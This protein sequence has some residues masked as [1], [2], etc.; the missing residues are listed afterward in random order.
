[1]E[2]AEA[3]FECS[4]AQLPCNQNSHL[5]AHIMPQALRLGNRSCAHGSQILQLCKCCF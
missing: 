5:T 1:M 4:A 2:E 3:A